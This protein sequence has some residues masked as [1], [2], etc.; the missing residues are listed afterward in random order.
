MNTLEKIF[1][2]FELC[3]G[4]S[5]D[6]RKIAAGSLFFALRGGNFDGNRFVLQALEKGASF[7]VGDCVEAMIS[8]SEASGCDGSGA[9]AG[10]ERVEKLI[11]EGKIFIVDD[12]LAALQD[13]ARLYRRKLALPILAITG[14]NGKTTTKELLARVLGQK[15][16]LSVTCGNLNNHIGVPLTLLKIDPK[17]EFAIVEMGASNPREIE[18]LASIAEPNFGLITNIGKAHLEG[19]GGIEG[20]RRGKG[21]L[22]DFLDKNGGT[23][24]YLSDSQALEQI[25]AEHP[26]LKTVHYSV[27]SW[28]PIEGRY[29]TAVFEGT[30]FTSKLTGDYNIINMAA[31]QCVGRYFGLDNTAIAS[32]IESYAPD[33][34]RSQRVETAENTIICD[35]YNANPSSMSAAIEAFMALDN[36]RSSRAVIL[37]GMLEL[38]EH[39]DAEHRAILDKIEQFIASGQINRAYF[40]GAQWPANASEKT[41]FFDDVQGLK[42]H[43]EADRIADSLILVKG[44]HSI[45]LEKIFEAL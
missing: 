36:S 13:L 37:G 17:S 23:L 11:S 20:V 44:S 29:A 21:E 30:K 6:T 16:R 31:A 5:T 2:A 18:L 42:S 1:A 8:G 39:N 9:E 32:A 12:S 27:A 35:A 26:N 3:G 4:V 10:R 22:A 25:V 19:F 40:V 28:T 45:A 7:A 24:F 43:L 38:G 14:S 41:L 34:N 15:F 33:N